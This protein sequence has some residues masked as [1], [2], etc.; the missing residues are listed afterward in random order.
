M[1]VN[2]FYEIIH[3]LVIYLFLRTHLLGYYLNKA[4][5]VLIPI[6]GIRVIL[7]FIFILFVT[8]IPDV[9]K[10]RFICRIVVLYF[11]VPW[12][13]LKNASK[14]SVWWSKPQGNTQHWFFAWLTDDVISESTKGFYCDLWWRV[15]PFFCSFF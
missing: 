4:C 13:F 11:V 10:S 2:L 1:L 3:L 14:W 12:S 15:F 7:L 9:C 6:V 5:V 8:T